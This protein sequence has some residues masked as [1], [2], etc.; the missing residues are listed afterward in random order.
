MADE[1]APETGPDSEADS[2]PVDEDPQ[3]AIE[4]HL[5]TVENTTF[6]G[7]DRLV[8]Q[9]A[10]LTPLSGGYDPE[11]RLE[12]V[13]GLLGNVDPMLHS[14]LARHLENIRDEARDFDKEALA[15]AAERLL[16]SLEPEATLEE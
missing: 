16:R 7:E 8:S 15:E 9:D 11:V 5:A 14:L 4:R 13:R 3:A 12:I 2:V 10:L 1:A 6:S